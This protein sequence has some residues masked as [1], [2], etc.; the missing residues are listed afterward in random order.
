MSKTLRRR[1]TGTR[2]EG[3]AS[4]VSI[5]FRRLNKS[6]APAMR[7]HLMRLD[8]H[9]RRMRFC[10]PASDVFIENRVIGLDWASSVIIG[11]FIDGMLRGVG[12]VVRVRMVP[13]SSAEIALSVEPSFQD[14]GIG[15]ELLRRLLVAARNRYIQKVFMLCLSENVKM[16]RV[17]R[18][19][20][21]DLIRDS[22]EVEGR[23]RTPWPSYQSLME[24]LMSDGLG[25]YQAVFDPAAVEEAVVVPETA[26]EPELRQGL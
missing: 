12:E 26:V 7:A 6:D 2:T 18:K 10:G 8:P 15:T 5:I 25:F 21:A 13:E 17:A 19:F 11:A 20:D 23:I 1:M 3:A 14:A 4:P 22:G 9:T 24:E 16:Q